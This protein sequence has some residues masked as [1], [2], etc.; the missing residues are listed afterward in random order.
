MY[1]GLC[2]N[3]KELR[4]KNGQILSGNN[5]ISHATNQKTAMQVNDAIS[6]PTSASPCPE[7]GQVCRDFSDPCQSPIKP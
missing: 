1:K 4:G 2:L 7:E 5:L 3:A 6:P